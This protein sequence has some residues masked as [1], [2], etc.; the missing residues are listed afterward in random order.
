M[1]GFCVNNL[2][3]QNDWNIEYNENFI[4]VTL[5]LQSFSWLMKHATEKKSQK[6]KKKQNRKPHKRPPTF[7]SFAID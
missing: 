5:K 7:V 6:T 2:C 1:K 4:D 3:R